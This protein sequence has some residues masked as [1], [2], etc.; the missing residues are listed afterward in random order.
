MKF[1]PNDNRVIKC[2]TYGDGRIEKSALVFLSLNTATVTVSVQFAK[3]A[4]TCSVAIL[5]FLNFATN[6]PKKMRKR[7]RKESTRN[8][9]Y[10]KVKGCMVK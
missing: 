5:P 7:V 3:M 6:W 8:V 2:A 10:V 9:L 1:L 4:L